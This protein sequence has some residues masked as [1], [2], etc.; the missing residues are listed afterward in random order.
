MRCDV[1]KKGQHRIIVFSWDWIDF[2][3]MASGTSNGH[4]EEDFRSG[5]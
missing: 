3:V 4:P 2:M 1:G 5:P